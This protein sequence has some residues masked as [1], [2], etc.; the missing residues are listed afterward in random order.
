MQA[1][2]MAENNHQQNQVQD[3]ANTLENPPD[4]SKKSHEADRHPFTPPV[5]PSSKYPD[6]VQISRRCAP[7]WPD[8]SRK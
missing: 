8:K 2:E 7:L 3:P 1:A 4:Q 6:E 5:R